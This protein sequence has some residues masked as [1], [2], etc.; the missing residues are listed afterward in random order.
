MVGPAETT[1]YAKKSIMCDICSEFKAKSKCFECEKMLCLKC[2]FKLERTNVN[3]PVESLC[4]EHY[5]TLQKYFDK[6]NYDFRNRH[7]EYC[8]I[9]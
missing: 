6:R 9:L 7:Y 1:N 5:D 2:K 4:E 8:Q 3:Y